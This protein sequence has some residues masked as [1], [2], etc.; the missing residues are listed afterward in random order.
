MECRRLLGP[1]GH[2]KSG[3]T[4]ALYTGDHANSG[5]Y[6]GILKLEYVILAR[7]Y[8]CGSG[9]EATNASL[10]IRGVASKS[11]YCYSTAVFCSITYLVIHGVRLHLN[12]YENIYEEMNDVI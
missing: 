8:A 10:D 11:T 6:T 7:Y 12:L 2:A 4:G 5:S 3:P 9:G 1:K